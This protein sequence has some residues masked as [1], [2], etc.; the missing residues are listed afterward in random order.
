MLVV[1]F[2]VIEVIVLLKNESILDSLGSKKLTY[3]PQLDAPRLW[4]RR[5]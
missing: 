1:I 5:R 3:M 2:L 4:L